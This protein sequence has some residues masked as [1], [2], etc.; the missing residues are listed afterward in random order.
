MIPEYKHYL[1]QAL[2]E[3]KA[4]KK[5]VQRL[6]KVKKG[7]ADSMIHE[8]HE[9]AFENID[10]L[11]CA[12]CC[13]GTG[14]LITQKDIE[15]IAKFKRLR[16]GEFVEKFLRIDEDQDYVF[17]KLPCSF[18]GEDNYCSIY[19]VRP[20]A[21]REYPHTDRINQQGIL[22]IT[23]KNSLICPAVAY[24]MLKLEI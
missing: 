3:K 24:I 9:E 13:S 4:I 12:N 15:R 16:P 10:C 20:K 19:E 6:K 14:P 5:K 17:K 23:S 11:K 8:L 7:E 18:L 1:V 22:S 2:A 21:C